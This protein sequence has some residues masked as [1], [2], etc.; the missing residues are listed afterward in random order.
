MLEKYQ[1]RDSRLLKSLAFTSRSKI[2]RRVR[3]LLSFTLIMS[4]SKA[5]MWKFSM[6][7]PEPSRHQS[8]RRGLPF[9]LVQCPQCQEGQECVLGKPPCPRKTAGTPPGEGAGRGIAPGKRRAFCPLGWGARK[10]AR[11][12]P[13]SPC[14]ESSSP[15][16]PWVLLQASPQRPPCPPDFLLL[17]PPCPREL[18]SL[19]MC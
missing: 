4:L 17:L 13:F 15:P 6:S 14:T 2:L 16:W 12:L 8:G 3:S 5:E 10:T 19:K 1:S 7:S 18:S 11:N 9:T